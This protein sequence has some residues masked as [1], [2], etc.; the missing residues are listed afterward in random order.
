MSKNEFSREKSENDINF[1]KRV[2]SC[3]LLILDDLGTEFITDYSRGRLFSIISNRLSYGLS[4]IITT[5]M[6]LSQIR[7]LY[8]E[9]IS[10][11]FIGD[12]MIIPFYGTDLRTTR[13]KGV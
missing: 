8:G 1:D 11:R 4:S 3:E 7:S 6:S 5:N 9:R 2:E 13:S 10:S 12:Y